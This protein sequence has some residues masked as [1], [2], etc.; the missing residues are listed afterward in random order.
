LACETRSQV[1][2]KTEYKSKVTGEVLHI[3]V[4]LRNI[5]ELAGLQG[6]FREELIDPQNFIQAAALVIPPEYS[7]RAHKH[8]ERQ[9]SFSRFMAQEA[10]V[11][12]DGS[13]VATYFDIDNQVLAEVP[14]SAG[15][16]SITLAGGH[17]YRTLDSTAVVIEFKTGPYEGQAVDKTFI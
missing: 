9:R 5:K 15:F 2:L 10:W 3:H 12:L 17:S 13:V 6:S 7:F 4:D 14:L 1:K 11:V 8:L 16:I